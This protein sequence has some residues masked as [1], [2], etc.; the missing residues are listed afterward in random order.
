MQKTLPGT[1]DYA[2]GTKLFF[3]ENPDHPKS[4]PVFGKNPEKFYKCIGKTNKIIRMER[5]FVE[6]K[7]RPTKESESRESKEQELKYV[8][9]ETYQEVLDKLLKPG[10]LPPR[11]VVTEKL[12]KKTLSR[13]ELQMEFSHEP[14]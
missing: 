3:A 8:I 11:T 1:H 9:T 4:D 2:I 6:P 10:Q 5:I 7:E 12:D 13:R 14:R